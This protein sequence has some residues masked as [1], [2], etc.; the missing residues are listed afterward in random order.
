MEIQSLGRNTGIQQIGPKASEQ[1]P[2]YW[3]S[4]AVDEQEVMA[5]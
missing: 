2:A 4:T 3:Q 5:Q 1:I